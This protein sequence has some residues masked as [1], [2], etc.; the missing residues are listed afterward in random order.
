MKNAVLPIALA[1][2]LAFT[3]Q[4]QDPCLGLI[5]NYTFNNTLNNLDGNEPFG[6]ASPNFSTGIFNQGLLVANQLRF[7]SISNLPQGSADRTVSMWLYRNSGTDVQQSPRIFAYG[8]N[9]AAQTFGAYFSTAGN[10]VFQGYGNGNDF[11]FG[12]DSNIPQGGWTHI[13]LTASGGTISGYVNS[14]LVGTF[15]PANMLNTGIGGLTI[16]SASTNIVVDDIRVY[17]RALSAAEIVMLYDTPEYSCCNISIP[18]ANFKSYLVGNTLINTSGDNE[19]QCTEAAAFTGNMYIPSLGIS[20]LTGIEAFVNLPELRCWDNQLTTLDL[21]ANTALTYLDCSGNQLTTLDL[22]ANSNLAV[23]GCGYNQLTSLD[24][25][26]NS[27]LYALR[28]YD[29]QITQLDLSMLPVLEKIE[30][31]NNALTYLN[32]ANGN[33]GAI[34]MLW[35]FNNPN[36][37]CIQVDDAAAVST[38]WP[39][40]SAANEDAFVYDTDVVFSETCLTSIAN[41]P[42]TEALALYPNPARHHITLEIEEATTIRL[43]NLLGEVLRTQTLQAGMNDLDISELA[44]GIYFIKTENGSSVK[45]VKE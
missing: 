41:L 10:L 28:C 38:A 23:L 42:E 30:C 21:T 20:D 26:M 40:G 6:A 4:A 8:S 32:L 16:G 24:L 29:N 17:D 11:D 37:D 43:V 34:W 31:E 9:N 12:S 14:T 2:A 22:A 45:F 19:I 7:T 35:A 13:T 3:A 44:S 15:S 1:T 27:A 25:S 39:N 18:D 36:L 5:T 33:N